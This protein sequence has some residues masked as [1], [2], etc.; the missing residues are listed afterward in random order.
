MFAKVKIIGVTGLLSI[1]AVWLS[2]P[3]QQAG[4]CDAWPGG[5]LDDAPYQSLYSIGAPL[6]GQGN[7]DRAAARALLEAWNA[8]GQPSNF[9]ASPYLKYGPDCEGGP[10]SASLATDN[11]TNDNQAKNDNEQEND[12][13]QEND[14][15]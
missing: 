2:M 11:P 9:D 7:V 6:N 3:T 12:N 10:G 8:A 15:N 1:A 5:G 14:N 13:G 4:A